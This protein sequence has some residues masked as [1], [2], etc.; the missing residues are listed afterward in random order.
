M[1][2]Q[3]MLYVV[4]FTC[5]KVGWQKGTTMKKLFADESKKIHVNNK[6]DSF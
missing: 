2:T 6:F 3:V 5:A 4:L 1:F